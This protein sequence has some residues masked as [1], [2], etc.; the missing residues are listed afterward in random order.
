M[1]KIGNIKFDFLKICTTFFVGSLFLFNLQVLAANAEVKVDATVDS[2]EIALGE[3]FNL[4]VVVSSKE[5]LD[6]SQPS[7]PSLKGFNLLNTF[8]SSGSSSRLVKGPQ[9]MVF[10]SNHHVTFNYSLVAVT[11]GKLTIDS[12][13]VNVEGKQYQTK[14]I[15]MTVVKDNG[16]AQNQ[17]RGGSLQRRMNPSPFEEEDPIAEAEEMFNQMLR[18]QG[19][20]RVPTPGGPSQGQQFPDQQ[21]PNQPP[22]FD[23]QF[24]T[25]PPSNKNEAFFLQLELDKNEAYEGEQITVNWYI[26]VRGMMESPERLKF[27][28]LKGFWKEI[29]EEVPAL[30]FQQ[31]VINGVVYHK[32]LLASHALFPIKAGKA[33]IDEFKVRA[34]VRLP[35]D[36]SNFGFGQPYT[37]TKA[38]QKV[39]IKVK[40]IPIENRPSDFAGA[41]GV[42]NVSAKTE[43]N[44]FIADEPFTLKIRFEGK[45]NAK[46]IDLPSLNLPPTLEVYSTKSQ[47]KFL[48]D[49]TSFK[50]FDVLLIPRQAGEFTIP[51][52]SFS[53]FDPAQQKYLQKASE[54]LQIKVTPST[55]MGKISSSPM[56]DPQKPVV[57]KPQLPDVM[58]GA[59]VG[60]I[61][62][63]EFSSLRWPLLI[64]VNLLVGVVLFLK[65]RKE[66]GWGQVKKDLK[67][68][69]MQRMKMVDE[70]FQK[71]DFRQVGI[72][73]INQFYFVMGE[74]SD[75]GGAN[76][77]MTKLLDHLPP[78]IRRDLG[79]N[80]SKKLEIFQSLG[81]APE[82]MLGK[83]KEKETLKKNLDESK[84]LLLKVVEMKEY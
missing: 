22:Q 47:S 61:K 74:V 42:F 81:F 59:S 70:A 63:E 65:A 6:A 64:I 48:K 32:A 10:E 69:I 12:I 40:P 41:V 82:E 26:Y 39:E 66:F 76:V 21:I 44:I 3:N 19:L 8:Q 36:A 37:Y 38:S 73:M 24:K 17:R 80:L 18:R 58:M 72:G 75:T 14:P 54:S 30:N 51:S 5:S 67:S 56:L 45:G 79:E 46:L 53:M 13:S 43:G 25:D 4:S 2:N 71:N 78:R 83:L 33:Y 34:K 27:P 57:A 1:I 52:I 7:L 49:G 77:E 84:E 23:P 60:S 29:I 62:G 16:Q 20:R 28:D 15:I 50:E 11:T 31:E 35:L 68:Q 55:G 9:G